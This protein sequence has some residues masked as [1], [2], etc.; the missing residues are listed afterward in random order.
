L[1]IERVFS[2]VDHENKA[3]QQAVILKTAYNHKKEFLVTVLA[4]NYSDKPFSLLKKHVIYEEN[5]Q[6]L[7]EFESGY[8][9]QIPAQTSM[10]WTFIFPSDCLKETP[11]GNSGELIVI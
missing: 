3:G 5:N 4:N 1:E 2:E 6:K 11:T 9:L 10:P 8:T 7:G